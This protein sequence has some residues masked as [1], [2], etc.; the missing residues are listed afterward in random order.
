MSNLT[1][2]Q[3]IAHYVASLFSDYVSKLMEY[4][5]TKY[6]VDPLALSSSLPAKFQEKPDH[7]C[8]QYEHPTAEEAVFTYMA[9]FSHGQ[10]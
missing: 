3:Y 10:I 9:R 1:K 7:L 2:I 8:A 5:F 4:L 6:C